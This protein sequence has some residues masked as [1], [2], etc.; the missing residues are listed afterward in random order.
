MS[1]QDSPGPIQALASRRWIDV[2]RHTYREFADDQVGI[3]EHGVA[4]GVAIAFFPGIALLVWLGTH[5]IGPQEAQALIVAISDVVPDSSR[6]I[7][8]KAVT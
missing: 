4:F 8:E 6:T 5:L 1:L 7:I 2:A 3:A